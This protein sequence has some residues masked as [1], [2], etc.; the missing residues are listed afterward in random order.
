MRQPVDVD[1]RSHTHKKAASARPVRNAGT[2]QGSPPYPRYARAA[3]MR[4]SACSA[5]VGARCWSN[6]DADV[7]AADIVIVVIGRRRQPVSTRCIR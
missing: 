1:K 4:R 5:A 3:S 6:R 7:K 2:Q